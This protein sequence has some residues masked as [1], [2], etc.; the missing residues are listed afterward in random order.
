[1]VP[2]V[3]EG[4]LESLAAGEPLVSGGEFLEV[5]RLLFGISLDERVDSVDTS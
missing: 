3:G 2:V 1:M 4:G 5:A